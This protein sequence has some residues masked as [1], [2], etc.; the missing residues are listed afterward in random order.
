MLEKD[1]LT[2]PQKVDLQWV[3]DLL[4]GHQIPAAGSHE[5][6]PAGGA[7]RRLSTR[8]SLKKVGSRAP[9]ACQEQA[10]IEDDA[11]GAII[12]NG[13][14]DENTQMFLLGFTSGVRQKR[15]LREV[16]NAI[17]I[18]IRLK[19]QMSGGIT[20]RHDPE[21]GAAIV[22]QLDSW[23]TFDIFEVDRN[24]NRK[25]LQAIA[26]AV[27]HKRNLL[28]AFSLSGSKVQKCI[29][30]VEANHRKENPYHNAIHAAD[31]I[32]SA[33]V[34]L[35]RGFSKGL[36][37]LE[38][39]S[40]IFAAANHDVGHPGLTNAYRVRE[41]DEAAI[42]Y[43]D[44]SVNENMSCALAYRILQKPECS[45]VNDA[46]SQK[47]RELMRKLVVK[48][49]LATDMEFHFS[50][51]AHLKTAIVDQG[52]SIETWENQLPLIE[53]AVHGADLS[54]ACKP[55]KVSEQWTDRVLAEFFE[56]GD[57]ERV[58]GRGIS[59]LC[60][61]KSV[62][63]P[64]SQVG[65]IDFIIKPTFQTISEL[66]DCTETLENMEANR[67][68]WADLVAKEK[69]AVQPSKQTPKG[70]KG[71]WTQSSKGRF[72]SGHQHLRRAQE[73]D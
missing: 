25:P 55:L 57:R 49:I 34:L 68:Y 52:T 73:D 14:L 65:F 26:T 39:L 50:N 44:I 60:D 8:G 20:P 15:T 61:R 30:E 43:S 47:Q 36:S 67:R 63:R 1:S 11:I 71:P 27:L 21:S 24:F 53:M 16:T 2:D 13:E 58:A 28:Q 22:P 7:N 18:G 41:V 19:K 46:L 23:N 59:P 64:G 70:K 54:N 69:A 38:V 9:L 45:F 48:T 17:R 33:H 37:D 10:E 32:Q 3:A 4:E 12:D 35:S 6:P 66:C 72:N 5:F 42:T 29:E 40:C 56:Q 51:L 62:S 31:V